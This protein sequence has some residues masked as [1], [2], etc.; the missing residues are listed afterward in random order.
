MTMAELTADLFGSLDGFAFGEDSGPYFG[1]QGPELDRWIQDTAGRPQLVLMGRVTYEALKKYS[2]PD[3]V[4][5]GLSKVVFSN[6]IQQPLGWANTR[7]V[8]G[9]LAEQIAELKRRSADP[10]RTFGSLMLVR[11]LMR[12]GLVDRLR[13]TIFPLVLGADGR[14]PIFAGHHRRAFELVDSKVLDSRLVMLEYRPT[15]G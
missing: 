10:I 11:S 14:E 12:L 15:A 6:T 7:L 5:T 13:L 2:S 4:V 9:D 3:D 1:Y 8:S